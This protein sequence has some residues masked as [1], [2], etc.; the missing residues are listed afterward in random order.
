M[1]RD[2]QKDF[3]AENGYLLVEDAVTQQQ[4]SRL[5]EITQQFIEASREVSESNDIYDL[6]AG[7]GPRRR[8]SLESRFHTDTTGISGKF[9]RLRG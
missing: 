3:Y 6:D 8:G 2:E 5:R 7:H 9:S 1:L 4:L